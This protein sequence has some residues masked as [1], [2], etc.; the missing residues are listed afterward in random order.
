MITFF[1]KQFSHI[2]DS[3]SAY[4]K[5]YYYLIENIVRTQSIAL[6]TDLNNRDYLAY[7]IFE[8]F[9]KTVGKNMGADIDYLLTSI[10]SQLIQE[11][12]VLPTNV[13]EIIISKFLLQPPES[14]LK[15]NQSL[16]VSAGYNLSKSIC[17]ENIEIMT[18][19]LNQ[20]FADIMSTSLEEED[21]EE[22]NSDRSKDRTI[23]IAPKSGRIRAQ[24]L[25]VKI[26][27]AVPELLV[28]IVG[29]LEHD[30]SVD[31][32]K[33]RELATVS[34]G[35]MLAHVP[36]RVNFVKKHRS[37]LNAWLSRINDK[38]PQIRA[39]WTNTL[40]DIII[41]RTDI[42]SDLSLALSDRLN[43]SDEKV[44]LA[45]CSVFETLPIQVIATKLDYPPLFEQ[46]YM[47][48]R[49]TKQVVRT[50]AFSIIGELY[51]A[52]YP[53]LADNHVYSALFASIPQII[54]Q[55]LF[56]NK[57]DVNEL[58]DITLNTHIL[59]SPEPSMLA[60]DRAKRILVVL[61][62]FDLQ[63]QKAF[64][65]ILER[66]NSLAGYTGYLA[67]MIKDSI[68]DKGEAESL[69]QK[70]DA[71]IKWLSL[72]YSEQAKA[73]ANLQ[74]FVTNA[75]VKSC[76]LLSNI[77]N[78]DNDFNAVQ[79][80]VHGLLNEV[81]RYKG[82][83]TA[84]ILRTFNILIYRA[85]YTFLNKSNITPIIQIST[86]PESKYQ[87]TAQK[88]LKTISEVLPALMKSHVQE[89]IT[90]IEAA[91]P[92]AKGNVETLEAAN[93]LAETF[94]DLIPQTSIFFESLVKI[95]LNGTPK[96]AAQAVR[97]ISASESKELYYN[98]VMVVATQ[99]NLEEPKLPT[100]LA[101]IAELY[102]YA[103]DMIETSH[104]QIQ[105]FLKHDIL[106]TNT[107]VASD[108]DPEWVDDDDIDID[109]QSKILA[110]HIF[111]N[112]LK[113]IIEEDIL[114][115]LSKPVLTLLVSLIGNSGEIVREEI[116]LTPSHY[117]AR[118]RLEAGLLL[119]DLA[120][121][122][123]IE[124]IISPKVIIKLAALVQDGVLEIRRRFLHTLMEYWSKEKISRR[125]ITLVFIAAHE[126]DKDFLH[127][128]TTWI[129]ARVAFENKTSN[130][131]MQMEK[132]FSYLLHILVHHQE[133]FDDT[134]DNVPEDIIKKQTE[135]YVLRATPYIV[136]FLVNVATEQ[137]ISLLFYI[138][139]RVKQYRDNVDESLSERLYLISDLSQFIIKRYHVFKDWSMDT[140]PGRLALSADIFKP[141][142]SSS[143]AQQVARTTY[144][145][146][147]VYD[148]LEKRLRELFAKKNPTDRPNKAE[149]SRQK[150]RST[151]QKKRQA[152]PN[153]AKDTQKKKRKVKSTN[154]DDDFDSKN[155]S[156]ELTTIRRSRRNT[157]PKSSMKDISDSEINVMDEESE[158]SEDSSGDE[159]D[160]NESEENEDQEQET[161]NEEEEEQE[162]ESEEAEENIEEN[163]EEVDEEVAEDVH[164]ETKT[165][166]RRGRYS[167]GSKQDNNRPA[168]TS[169]NTS[170]A[171][172]KIQKSV[173][174]DAASSDATPK[175]GRPRKNA[176]QGTDTVLSS[177]NG[178]EKSQS[179]PVAIGRRRLRSSGQA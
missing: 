57:S 130:N 118:L 109:C 26:W 47:R 147:Y 157:A 67:T 82:L 107:V 40:P 103:P 92:G 137:N 20:Y 15:D 90:I 13:V 2:S 94:H 156:A 70:I 160:D 51:N 64:E 19:H 116:G 80:S 178:N 23:D 106:L 121:K 77:V 124:K 49:D 71:T 4:F 85:G 155:Q 134:E 24:E 140:W 102:T 161:T 36:S 76:K 172:T 174:V 54:I 139:Q 117:K 68:S 31:N 22:L 53:Y 148:P 166:R 138:S 61:D 63:G 98:E 11:L 56:V 132:S 75:T 153:K 91:V 119:L 73:E 120:S 135:E 123:S 89:L 21:E 39:A 95:S 97:L 99:L 65:K 170:T 48:L 88:F 58:I 152:E 125:F 113:Q 122:R 177:R 5:L 35:K 126:P 131:K 32:L 74:S 17:T 143:V 14:S 66:Q 86:T 158:E 110:L 144:L 104:E 42:I 141:M 46:L 72:S 100:Y 44:R 79:K 60:E 111:V 176:S 127:Y 55:Q 27:N 149:S 93:S 151:K 9:Y 154:N 6:V 62:S 33:I 41:N 43:D 12:E 84:S 145:P 59:Q 164:T 10:L 146:E 37:T 175:R 150:E 133:S 136:F 45:A 52:A 167:R 25:A 7:R 30:L 34:I 128:V 105:K 83:A 81:K 171:S 1:V 69:K 50:E 108:S 163:A 78:P 169:Q 165:S 3:K 16:P 114:S 112:R 142:P 28:N 18:R 96:E 8:I 38:S 159:N 87:Q 101:A 29:Q 168:K 115:E 162:E 129:R 179:Q 173:I